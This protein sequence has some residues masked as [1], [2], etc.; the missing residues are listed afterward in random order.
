LGR[1]RASLDAFVGNLGPARQTIG[2]AVALAERA[3][4]A[5]DPS[6]DEHDAMVAEAASTAADAARLAA[7]KGDTSDHDRLLGR[8]RDLAGRSAGPRARRAQGSVAY[9]QA[10]AKLSAL[11]ERAKSTRA[12]PPREALGGVVQAVVETVQLRRAAADEDDKT[13]LFDL[14]EALALHGQALALS[15]QTSEAIGALAEAGAI[16]DRFTGEGPAALT[17]QVR[18]PLAQ[19]RRMSR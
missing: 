5:V 19:L 2:E 11:I 9:A 17:D 8:A 18:Q 7:A 6:D 15:D 10:S 1:W 14:A 3:L 13:T 12:V 16:L 4:S